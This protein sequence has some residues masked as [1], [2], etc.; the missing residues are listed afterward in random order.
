M[1]TPITLLSDRFADAARRYVSHP[2][3]HLDLCS[4]SDPRDPSLYCTP[5]NEPLFCFLRDLLFLERDAVSLASSN[6]SAASAVRLAL[7]RA[8]LAT[9]LLA[10]QAF[11]QSRFN[12]SL[13]IRLSSLLFSPLPSLLTS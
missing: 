7:L 10:L 8:N 2:C 3:S 6:L 13:I 5:A 9:R 11:I 4:N 12:L 1:S